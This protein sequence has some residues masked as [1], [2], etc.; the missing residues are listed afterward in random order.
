[1]FVHYHE[2]VRYLQ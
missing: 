2:K 1:M